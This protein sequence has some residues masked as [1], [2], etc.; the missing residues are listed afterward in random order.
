[1][2]HRCMNTSLVYA[3]HM[4]PALNGSSVL[5]S[6]KRGKAIENRNGIMLGIYLGL[7]HMHEQSMNH[8]CLKE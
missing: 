8:I 1:M 7:S 6:F 3:L 4:S 5:Q 2:L